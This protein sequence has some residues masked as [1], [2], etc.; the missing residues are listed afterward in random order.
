VHLLDLHTSSADGPPFLT[1]GDT[2]QNRRFARHFPVPVILGLEEQIDGALLEYAGELG[3]MTL[4]VETG[5]HDLETSVDRHEAVLWVA[6]VGAG[7]LEPSDAPEWARSREML[8]EAARGLPR[9]TEVRYRHAI[10][11]REEFRM[12]P[13]FRNFQPIRKGE[14]LGESRDGPV[15]AKES[16]VVLLPLYQALGD[17]GFFVGREVRSLWLKLSALLRSIGLASWSHILPGVRRHPERE[18]TLIVNTRIARI[19]PLDLF[20]LLGYRKRRW[21]GNLLLVSRRREDLG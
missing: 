19:Y 1:M 11:P 10:R 6:L 15:R 9:I 16:G 12:T 21:Q 14:I 18:N 8:R 20:H 5:R 7:C 2:L 4:G 17:D 3:H 13:G